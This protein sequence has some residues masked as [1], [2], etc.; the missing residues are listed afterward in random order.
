MGQFVT[1]LL[2]R[3][4]L[5]I[6]IKSLE[7]IRNQLIELDNLEPELDLEPLPKRIEIDGVTPHRHYHHDD[8]CCEGMRW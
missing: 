8:D 5:Q 4:K 1:N 2:Y 3:N 6:A 7:E